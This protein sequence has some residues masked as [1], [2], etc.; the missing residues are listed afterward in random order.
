MKILSIRLAELLKSR[1]GVVIVL[2]SP[3]DSM[4]SRND[5]ASVS[6]WTLNKLKLKSPASRIGVYEG[7]WDILNIKSSIKFEALFDVGGL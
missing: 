2:I 5:E 6:S 7:I 1:V 4:E 3:T